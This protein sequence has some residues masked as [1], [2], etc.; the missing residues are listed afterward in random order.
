MTPHPL[1]RP[2]WSSLTTR[3]ARF[4]VGDA[5]ALR[6]AA[7][8]SPFAA[9]PDDS[10][11]SL[12]ALTGLIMPGGAVMV[13][14]DKGFTAPAGTTIEKTFPI[15][16][17]AAQ[18]LTGGADESG[19]EPLTDAD[20]PEM[21]AL[22]HLTEP[23]PFL[24]RTHELGAFWGI[25]HGGRLVAMAGERM[26]PEGF[27]EVSGVCTHPDA[28]GKGYARKLSA[29]IAARIADRGE[30]PFLHSFAT[31]TNAN[32]LYQS[33]GFTPW[34]DVTAILLRRT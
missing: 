5:R 7:D 29:F 8:V 11:E 25:K 14:V 15:V 2:V 20:A 27:T 24:P 3:H 33:L 6:Y 19:L 31:N 16:R 26:R 1:D 12:A 13:V 22:A 34:R 30:T 28:R 18:T 4:A 10:P 9:T 23:G 32:R 21:M 17:M